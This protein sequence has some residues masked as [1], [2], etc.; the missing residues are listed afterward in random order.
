MHAYQQVILQILILE[1]KVIK[2]YEN[3]INII[4]Y[5]YRSNIF[6]VM[7]GIIDWISVSTI[8]TVWMQLSPLLHKISFQNKIYI[9]W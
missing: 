8:L 3:S 7:I 2:N 5:W 6:S 9:K 4:P 1:F